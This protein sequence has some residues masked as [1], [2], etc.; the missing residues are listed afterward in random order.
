MS[1]GK[2]IGAVALG[3]ATAAVWVG[4]KTIMYGSK[5]LGH[6]L[7]EQAKKID[8][9]QGGVFTGSDG[10][11]YTS[12]DLRKV[13]AACG[14][15]SAQRENC[16]RN[17]E[18]FEKKPHVTEKLF[19]S[20]FDRACENAFRSAVKMWREKDEMDEHPA[21]DPVPLKFND[22]DE[23][24]FGECVKNLMDK[25]DANKVPDEVPE[26]DKENDDDADHAADDA[27]ETDDDDE[28][29]DELDEPVEHPAYDPVTLEL[30]KKIPI[31]RALSP[32]MDKPGEE[33]VLVE[34]QED[35]EEND[36]DADHAADDAVETDDDDEDD[37]EEKRR[38]RA[39]RAVRHFA[40]QLG[41][42]H[43]DDSGCGG[44]EEN[45]GKI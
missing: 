35:N 13:A 21:D 45:P 19:G 6:A 26:C 44:E 37:D 25:L 2:K 23:N 10:R 33:K 39:M 41:V 8:K 32:N 20:K 14:N 15:E 18:K 28:D 7:N 4:G 40:E 16:Y 1:V 31:L 17:H 34:D 30:I 12:D 43:F 24:D 5:L 29:E 36:D 38:V 42:H 22:F 3:T 11:Q 27:V 9:E